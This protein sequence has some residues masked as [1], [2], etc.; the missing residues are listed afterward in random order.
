VNFRQER[1]YQH[2]RGRARW[3]LAARPQIARR[4]AK[5]ARSRRSIA[6]G[7]QT[8]RGCPPF[9]SFVSFRRCVY[10]SYHLHTNAHCLYTIKSSCSK[11]VLSLFSKRPRH[12]HYFKQDTDQY[13]AENRQYKAKMFVYKRGM[14]LL[15]TSAIS[16]KYGGHWEYIRWACHADSRS[17]R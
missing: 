8:V 1:L 12:N 9:K 11:Q 2:E 10:A 14:Y 15:T 16:S 13:Q 7:T 6:S 5:D 3:C 4:H 17:T